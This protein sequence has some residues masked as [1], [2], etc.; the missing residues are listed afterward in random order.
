[1]DEN[2]ISA[3]CF[4]LSYVCRTDLGFVFDLE[5]FLAS[6][7]EEREESRQDVRRIISPPEI[8]QETPDGTGDVTIQAPKRRRGRPRKNPVKPSIAHPALPLLNARPAL[9]PLDAVAVDR[10]SSSEGDEFDGTADGNVDNDAVDIPPPP[11]RRRRQMHWPDQSRV[12]PAVATTT[13]A[14]EDEERATY[15]AAAK[16]MVHPRNNA[17]V[18]QPSVP[19]DTSYVAAPRPRSPMPPPLPPAHPQFHD[20][21]VPTSLRSEEQQ[22]DIAGVVASQP[23]VPPPA[24]PPLAHYHENMMYHMNHYHDYTALQQQQQQ[25]QER[26]MEHFTDSYTS[27]YR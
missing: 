2:V 8:V 4:N 6:T 26:R 5:K 3:Q 10:D 16:A 19:T 21:S 12:P 9:P 14:T 23:H 1:M 18:P 11:A 15:V 17:Y 27:Y 25:Q 24:L 20:A 7:P 13:G 22:N